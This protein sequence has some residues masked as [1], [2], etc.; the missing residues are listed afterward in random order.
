[1]LCFCLLA[2]AF[3]MF[4]TTLD[5]KVPVKDIKMQDGIA[6]VQTLKAHRIRPGGAAPARVTLSGTG[7]Y[8]GTYSAWVAGENKLELLGKNGGPLGKIVDTS[9]G[10]IQQ[11]YRQQ[12][13]N[14]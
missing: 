2:C 12:L 4:M 5:R 10:F 11:D 8:D 14:S 13:I 3:A 9:L 6:R 1:M 7:Q